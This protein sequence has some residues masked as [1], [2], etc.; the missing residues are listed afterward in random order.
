MSPLDGLSGEHWLAEKGKGC[1]R[2]CLALRHAP[3]VTPAAQRRQQRRAHYAAEAALARSSGVV[4]AEPE[5][6]SVPH[7]LEV[8]W[9]HSH[10]EMGAAF[11]EKAK[12]NARERE[13]NLR[14]SG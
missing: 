3:A 11:M 14:L 13:F 12:E 6:K 9:P 5:V 2:T 1:R 4:P 8:P 7:Q 10:K